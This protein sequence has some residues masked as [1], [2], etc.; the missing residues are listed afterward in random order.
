MTDE[1]M[2]RSWRGQGEKRQKRKCDTTACRLRH[3]DRSTHDSTS[4]GAGWLQRNVH[5]YG[6]SCRT[7]LKLR[8]RERARVERGEVRSG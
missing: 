6:R 5:L 1:G 7:Y 2:E 4:S 8:H 3:G